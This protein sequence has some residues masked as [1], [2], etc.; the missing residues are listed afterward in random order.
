[1]A[2]FYAYEL[3]LGEFNTED[4]GSLLAFAYFV[5]A[6]M[7]NLIIMLNLLIAIISQTHSDV[8]SNRELSTYQEK[9]SIISDFFY[10]DKRS[11]NQ[12]NGT[13][14]CVI[15]EKEMIDR[16]DEAWKLDDV[17]HQIQAMKKSVDS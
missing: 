11:G 10:L 6:T 2:I 1:M 5:M 17:I 15:K 7:F 12:N 16:A 8:T 3:M 13:M 4:Y 9:A 14:L